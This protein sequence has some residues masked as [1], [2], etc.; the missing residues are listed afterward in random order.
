MFKMEPN[1]LESF[2]FNIKHSCRAEITKSEQDFEGSENQPSQLLNILLDV[3][4]IETLTLLS[5]WGYIPIMQ[6]CIGSDQ[7]T[8][9]HFP[10]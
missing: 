9:Q 5:S 8:Q 4:V 3:D 2:H 7:R 6:R 10:P 1:H